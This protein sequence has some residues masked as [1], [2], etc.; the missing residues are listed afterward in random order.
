MATL[1]MT[2]DQGLDMSR[3]QGLVALKVAASKMR[4]MNISCRS[5]Q[6]PTRV[7]LAV[8]EEF[9][10][11][12]G[13]VTQ[14]HWRGG[15]IMLQ[16]L[17]GKRA[18]PPSPTWTPA[19][20]REGTMPPGAGGRSVGRRPFADPDGERRRADRSGGVERAIVVPAIPSTRG[21]RV[22]ER[23]RSGGVFL[24]TR[25]RRGHAQEL[26]ADDRKDMV[27]NG[28]ISV[29]CEFCNAQVRLHAGRGG[30]FRRCRRKDTTGNL[31]DRCACCP[32]RR[33]RM[34]GICDVELLA[35]PPLPFRRSPS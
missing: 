7:R 8:A 14:H 29:T 30:R 25:W 34:S 28:V 2:I 33:A 1:A 15:G 27:E 26:P 12:N 4:R 20:R 16:F 31:V 32:A 6:I 10:A 9:R 11:G 3:Y 21:T 17:P 35:L 18:Y 22:Q 5:E 24:L 13:G 23:R 19:M